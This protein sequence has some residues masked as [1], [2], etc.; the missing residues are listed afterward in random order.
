M[1]RDF[2]GAFESTMEELKIELVEFKL[3]VERYNGKS[4]RLYKIC[5]RIIHLLRV[6]Y[7]LKLLHLSSGRGEMIYFNYKQADSLWKSQSILKAIIWTQFHIQKE[8]HSK[9]RRAAIAIMALKKRKCVDRNLLRYMAN[10]IWQ[11]QD[12]VQWVNASQLDLRHFCSGRIKQT[13]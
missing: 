10:Y 7:K 9:C 3:Q 6:R 13:V 4:Q 11:T 5:I 12:C 8:K 2:V 1:N